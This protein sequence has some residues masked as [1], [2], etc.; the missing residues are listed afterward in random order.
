MKLY[1][2][3]YYTIISKLNLYDLES[4]FG[5]SQVKVKFDDDNDLWLVTL[6][7]D[8]NMNSIMLSSIALSPRQYRVI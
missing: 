8:D 1:H 4:V 3:S 6:L 2:P 7:K 5:L